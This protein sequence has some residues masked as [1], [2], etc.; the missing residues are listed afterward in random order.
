MN[1]AWNNKLKFQRLPSPIMG[2]GSTCRT[3]SSWTFFMKGGVK[4]EVPNRNPKILIPFDGLLKFGDKPKGDHVMHLWGW[5]EKLITQNLVWKCS[6][7]ND[8]IEK[9]PMM[10]ISF[11]MYGNKQKEEW[12]VI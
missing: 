5:I 8:T 1:V 9:G 7:A 6:Y 2:S 12:L 10:W 11:T 3:S 4:V